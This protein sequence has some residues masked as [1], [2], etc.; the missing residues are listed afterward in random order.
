MSELTYH[1]IIDAFI[2]LFVQVLDEVCIRDAINRTAKGVLLCEVGEFARN[3]SERTVVSYPLASADCRRKGN[4]SLPLQC[5]YANFNSLICFNITMFLEL[6][7]DN[8]K[9]FVDFN[10]DVITSLLV[11]FRPLVQVQQ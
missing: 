5:L 2:D 9:K 11:V 3:V 8:V 1:E 7:M 6:G 10:A 4:D